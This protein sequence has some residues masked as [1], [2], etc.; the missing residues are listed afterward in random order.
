MFF[1]FTKFPGRTLEDKVVC[2]MA[3]KE[4]KRFTFLFNCS[5]EEEKDWELAREKKPTFLIAC[6]VLIL[7]SNSCMGTFCP[8]S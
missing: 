3:N 2:S 8:F 6:K 1:S 7:S 4:N 5:H